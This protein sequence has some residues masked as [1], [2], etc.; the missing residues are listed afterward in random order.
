MLTEQL[1]K[2]S[3]IDQLLAGVQTADGIP[4]H[5]HTYL[6]L[7]LLQ[8]LNKRAPSLDPLVPAELARAWSAY[9]PLLPTLEAFASLPMV[10][11]DNDLRILSASFVQPLVEQ[12]RK[13]KRAEFDAVMAAFLRVPAGS[14]A[15]AA[16]DNLRLSWHDFVYGTFLTS[17]RVF[18][19]PIA[20]A[21]LTD[22]KRSFSTCVPLADMLSHSFQPNAM[23][24]FDS[25]R[26]VFL[27]HLLCD[28]AA[29]DE[30]TIEYGR[31]CN[32][33][34]LMQ[35]GFC[36]PNNPYNCAAV[37]LLNKVPVFAVPASE[38]EGVDTP[39]V[40]LIR[41]FFVHPMYTNNAT[42]QTFTFLR[43]SMITFTEPELQELTGT[44]AFQSAYWQMTHAHMAPSSATESACLVEREAGLCCNG[45][46][47]APDTDAAKCAVRKVF[48]VLI[49]PLA[50]RC[51]PVSLRNEAAVLVTL[52]QACEVR[53]VGPC[54]AQ[55]RHICLA[56][57]ALECFPS[58]LEEDEAA[59]ASLM[60]S[61]VVPPPPP[62]LPPSKR[63]RGGGKRSP[64]S[65]VARPPPRA[66]VLQL[67]GEK[68]VL[69]FWVALTEVLLPIAAAITGET[70]EDE[71]DDAGEGGGAPAP[72]D[73][74]ALRAQ[75]I[76]AN[77][78]SVLVDDE[79]LYGSPA[80]RAYIDSV[81]LPLVREYLLEQSAIADT[82][83]NA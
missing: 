5:T 61:P 42:E 13:S 73:L 81:F 39:H 4:L 64:G 77:S 50:F 49:S 47:A 80:A 12:H 58:T 1:A 18:G 35:Y 79:E 14:P 23:W 57:S 36:V 44:P 40:E 33:N 55:L 10:I 46:L 53:P 25:D 41:P 67:I 65:S 15:R 21:K 76:E 45:G 6:T 38:R 60:E 51:K 71:E 56:Q 48:G 19:V 59:L 34:L 74:A 52:A 30:I 70:A 32:S 27:I 8:L 83:E 22:A 78:A 20:G 9:M 11:E 2:G 63:A 69:Q 66:L 17:T 43:L 68:K 26:R 29:G 28:V 72:V 31:K 37:I 3:L 7:F 62:S 24:T 54:A 75:Y 16:I 82:A